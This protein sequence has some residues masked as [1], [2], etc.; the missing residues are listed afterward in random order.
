[1]NL[2]ETL[3]EAVS[4]V[5]LSLGKRTFMKSFSKSSIVEVDLEKMIAY[6]K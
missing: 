3:T 2:Y 1:M 4:L 5:Y 6:D